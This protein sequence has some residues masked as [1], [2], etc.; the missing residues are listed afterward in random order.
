MYDAELGLVYYNY[1][2]YN[3]L[4]G[5]WTRRD[6]FQANY[7]YSPY[8]F[9]AN[10]PIKMVD[11]LGTIITP[12]VGYN[13]TRSLIEDFT[14]IANQEYTADPQDGY[15]ACE[16]YTQIESTPCLGDNGEEED[17]YPIEAKEVCDGFI[18]MYTKNGKL[19]NA[20]LCVAEC[21]TEAEKSNGAHR[22][23]N[24]RSAMRLVSHF[25]CYIQ[26]GF[27]MDLSKE[28]CGVP[29]NGLDVGFNSLISGT[30]DYLF[31]WI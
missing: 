14:K 2:Y 9:S 27:F 28:G 25:S 4:D 10:Q 29:K 12:D 1:R 5:R 30:L 7:W 16:K 20:V 3:P 23:C 13:Y 17:T 24:K 8:H 21:L 19:R 18:T 6:I 26:C 11:L 22:C 15:R 31:E